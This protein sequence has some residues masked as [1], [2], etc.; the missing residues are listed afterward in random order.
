MRRRRRRP[1]NARVVPPGPRP[2]SQRPLSSVASLRTTFR[3]GQRRSQ[4]RSGLSHRGDRLGRRE[5]AAAPARP[6]RPAEG[7]GR[8]SSARALTGPRVFQQQVCGMNPGC[9]SFRQGEKNHTGCPPRWVPTRRQSRWL[10]LLLKKNF[11]VV[12]F[13][14][15]LIVDAREVARIPRVL[16]GTRPPSPQG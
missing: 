5:A 15:E 16:L 12:C 1:R 10:R 8:R 3:G 6:P 11:F 9:L 2:G 7:P 13:Y 14:F 4:P